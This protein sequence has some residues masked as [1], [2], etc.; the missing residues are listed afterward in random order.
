MEQ[1]TVAKAVEPETKSKHPPPRV[2]KKKEKKKKKVG[3][4]G[5][6]GRKGRGASSV[7]CI[8]RYRHTTVQDSGDSSVVRAPDS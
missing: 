3:L 7:M 8:T 5:G 2:K 4:G 6:G 1:N